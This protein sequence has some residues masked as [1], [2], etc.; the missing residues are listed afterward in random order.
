[1]TDIPTGNYGHYRKMVIAGPLILIVTIL[2]VLTALSPSPAWAQNF[3]TYSIKAAISENTVSEEIEITFTGLTDLSYLIDGDFGEVKVSSNDGEIEYSVH[4]DP[5]SYIVVS[6]LKDKNHL[7]LQFN[8]RAPIRQG[9][10]G[11][12]ALFKVR[13]PINVTQFTMTVILPPDSVPIST[14]NTYSIF[15]TPDEQYTD[16]GRYVVEWREDDIEEGD[17][18]IF[19]IDY[20]RPQRQRQILPYILTGVL[21]FGIIF[22]TIYY[23]K[24]KRE[25][26]LKGLSQDERAVIELVMDGRKDQ[27]DIQ[28][29][30]EFNKVKMTRVVQRLEKKGVLKK[31]RRGKRNRLSLEKV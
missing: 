20:T 31:E 16:D 22:F 8:T 24:R 6:G 30:L 25:L 26:F 12:E 11:T 2:F 13:F 18:L 15:P 29:I 21:V 5:Q 14:K 19:S 4:S 1:M 17:E 27:Q 3:D 10:R 28:N 23:K 9:K 7:K